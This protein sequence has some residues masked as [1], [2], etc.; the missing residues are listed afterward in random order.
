MGQGGNVLASFAERRE[1]NPHHVEAVVQVVPKTAFADLSRQILVGGGDH[2]DV[3]P[4]GMVAADR[5]H[6]LLPEHAE[7]LGLHV[8]ADVSDLVEEDRAAVPGLKETA[9]RCDSARERAANVSEEFAFQE[10]LG[11]SGAVD[12]HERAGGRGPLK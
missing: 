10:A 12:G 9:P 7:K 5:S 1:L 8:R 2:A 3:H 11:Q 4:D 6:L